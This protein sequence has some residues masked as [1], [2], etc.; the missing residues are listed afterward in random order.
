MKNIL[1]SALILSLSFLFFSFIKKT[2]HTTA[3]GINDET[4]ITNKEVVKP[5]H[6][7][8]AINKSRMLYEKLELG[9]KGLSIEAVESAFKGYFHL[10]QQKLIKNAEPL[11]IVD[12]SQSSR[13]KRFYIINMKQEKLIMNSYV[14][15]GKN[16]GLDMAN[17]FSNIPESEKSSIGF[18]LTKE[19]YTGKNGYSLKMSGLEKNYNDNAE[20]RAIVVHGA[21]YVN[22]GR[23]QSGFMGRSQGCPA[24]PK[25][26]YIKAIDEIKNGSVFFIYY[27][28]SK[29]LQSS[30]LLNS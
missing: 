29:Y 2:D 9:K 25:E 11:T 21:D 30:E 4:V 6:N 22:A 19:T 3:P 24:L 10:Q 18:Y 13:K 23:V 17:N 8:A 7:S 5:D 15:H 28:M 26:D 1:L 20:K 12:F 16:T 27:P 14:A